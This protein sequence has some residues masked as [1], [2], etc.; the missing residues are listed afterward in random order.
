MSHGLWKKAMSRRACAVPVG[1]DS[2]H[3]RFP[4]T[5]VLG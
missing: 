2:Y 4:S 5:C 1:L 3:S